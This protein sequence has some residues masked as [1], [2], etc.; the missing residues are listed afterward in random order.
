[1]KLYIIFHEKIVGKYYESIFPFMIHF[2][3]SSVTI[4]FLLN[5]LTVYYESFNVDNLDSLFSG[6]ILKLLPWLRNDLS[7]IVM[8]FVEWLLPFDHIENPWFN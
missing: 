1:M 7:N 8:Y 3:F 5:I 2:V 4:Y 6:I